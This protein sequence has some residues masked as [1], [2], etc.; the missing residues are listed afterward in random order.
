MPEVESVKLQLQKYLVGHTIGDVE[1]KNTKIFQGSVKD[2]VGAKA[3]NIRR[4]AKVLSVDLSN[5]N[6]LL[7]H[8]KLTGQLI[9]RGPNL[10]SAPT[11]SEK[12]V[13]GVPGPHTHVIFKLDRGGH[14]Y[15]NDVRRFGWLKVVKTKDVE[16]L[17][18]VGKLGP[19]PFGKLTLEYFRNVLANTKRAVKV[20]LMDQSKMGG[21]GNIYATDALWLAKIDPKRAASSLDQTERKELYE[22]IHTVLKEGIKYGGATALAYVRPDGTEGSYQNHTLA[23]GKE[24]TLCPRCKKTKFKK[25]FLSGRGT[26]VCERCQ[27]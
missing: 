1:V 7:I 23:Y 18:F 22:A 14:L 25:Y 20:V 4:F 5:H 9:Y 17:G 2:V 27:K 21:V 19:E 8:V 13:G 16:T 15:Y 10:G 11:L 3:K 24:G 12:V 6:S 26:Y